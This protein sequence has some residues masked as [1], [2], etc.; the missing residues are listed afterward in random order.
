MSESPGEEPRHPR[1][2]TSDRSRGIVLLEGTRQMGLAIAAQTG[3][4]LYDVD[5]HRLQGEIVL[6]TVDSQ[7]P[8]LCPVE[9]SRVES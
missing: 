9:E 1:M 4:L 6:K 7:E 5:R 2:P 8:A 3:Q